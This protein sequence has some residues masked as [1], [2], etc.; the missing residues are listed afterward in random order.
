MNHK[1]IQ[2]LWREGGLRVPQKRR[3]KRLG[4]ST[5]PNLPF[6]DAPDTELPVRVTAVPPPTG[7]LAGATPLTIGCEK[8]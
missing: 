8:K 1:K 5:T 4:T 2:R 7:P 6:A 3:R